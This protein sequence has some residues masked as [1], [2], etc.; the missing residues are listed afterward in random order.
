M[1]CY[2]RSRT[3]CTSEF[4]QTPLLSTKRLSRVAVGSAPEFPGC[5]P[6]YGQGAAGA[7]A[8]LGSLALSAPITLHCSAATQETGSLFL[9]L[10][11]TPPSVPLHTLP[12]V[13][14]THPPANDA[15]AALTTGPPL[16]DLRGISSARV[17]LRVAILPLRLS[18]KETVA[19]LTNTTRP[20]TIHRWPRES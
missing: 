20:R 19:R 2:R 12:P 7:L 8:C 5:R 13:G 1:K 18:R 15:P 3:L 6:L 11:T 10:Q 9:S 17:V 4:K 16:C 14:Q